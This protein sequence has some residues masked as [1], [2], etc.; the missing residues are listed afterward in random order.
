MS[1]RYRASSLPAT[2]SIAAQLVIVCTG[3]LPNIALAEQSDRPLRVETDEGFLVDD[4]LRTSEASIYAAGSVAALPDRL[5]GRAAGAQPVGRCR[6]AGG[7][8]SRKACR[9]GGNIPTPSGSFVG[10]YLDRQALARGHR[11]HPGSD[12]GGIDLD[13]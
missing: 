6:T 4:W 8:C 5:L 1:G 12:A 10:H 2:R 13:G 9:S 11:R 7:R 3:T